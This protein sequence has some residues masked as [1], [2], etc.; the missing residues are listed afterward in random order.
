[1][2]GIAIVDFAQ[3]LI[4]QPQAADSPMTVLVF[5]AIFEII[6]QG[7]EESVINSI[8]HRVG[9][10]IRAKQNAILILDEKRATA[11]QG[12]VTKISR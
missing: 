8:Q 11:Y 10:H 4:R 6:V 12:P 2:P 5:F 9:A 7:F 1:M 3:N